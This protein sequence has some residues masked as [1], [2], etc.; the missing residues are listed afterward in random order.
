MI[1]LRFHLIFFGLMGTAL[2]VLAMV[3][4]LTK[5]VFLIW[6]A[7]CL[8]S[9]VYTPIIQV[10]IEE[11]ERTSR[12]LKGLPINNQSIYISAQLVNSLNVIWFYCLPIAFTLFISIFL[13]MSFSWNFFELIATFIL[14]CFI[15][16][17]GF[18]FHFN[19]CD[20]TYVKLFIHIT[21]F[22]V[23][24]AA[25]RN[26]RKTEA[27]FQAAIEFI[28]QSD[29]FIG[30]AFAGIVAIATIAFILGNKLYCNFTAFR[31]LT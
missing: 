31:R 29:F 10:T 25:T 12:N 13:R 5:N 19:F 1:N 27:L 26:L 9:I 3:V 22:M 30:T 7:I 24:Y 16:V 14:L 23:I 21:I 4:F 6:T 11:N 17:V 2:S 8:T 15:S 20:S 28:G 18:A